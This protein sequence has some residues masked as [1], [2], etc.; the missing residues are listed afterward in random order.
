MLAGQVMVGFSLS[1]MMT[2]KEQLVE[3]PEVSVA[4]QFTVLVPLLK[5]E[6]EGG[7]QAAIT[8]GQLS[9]ADAQ[10]TL[11]FEQVPRSVLAVI[12][13]QVRLGFS[14]SLTVMVKE[15]VAVF[16]EASVAVQMTVVAPFGKVEPLA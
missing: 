10:V 12:F 1:L 14:L 11:V 7:V 3:L 9:V 6:P 2:V 15:Q 5:V 13:A 8:P 16:P 4:L